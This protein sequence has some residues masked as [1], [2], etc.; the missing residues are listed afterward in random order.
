MTHQA[1]PPLPSPAD[2]GRQVAQLREVLRLVE[3]LAGQAG[4]GHDSALDEA[5]RVSIAYD[6]AAPIVRRRFDTRA[7]EAAS[8]AAAGVEALLASGD[9]PSEAAAARLARQIAGALGD[10]ANML[11]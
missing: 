9:A 5:A 11:D 8:W 10:L 6:R 7:A 2:P 4:A 1:P 3:G